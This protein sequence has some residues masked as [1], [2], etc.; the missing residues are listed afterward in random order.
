M[1]FLKGLQQ[2]DETSVRSKSADTE[3]SWYCSLLDDYH[4]KSFT[5]TSK[6]GEVGEVTYLYM[7]FQ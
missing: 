2:K 7:T 5:N 3:D 1:V 6:K 4:N